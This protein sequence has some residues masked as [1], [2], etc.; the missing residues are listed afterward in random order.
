MSRKKQGKTQGTRA[1][2]GIAV[3]KRLVCWYSANFT[4][5]NNNKTNTAHDVVRLSSTL[6]WSALRCLKSW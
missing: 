3:T 6:S 2:A 4:T 1:I 5:G